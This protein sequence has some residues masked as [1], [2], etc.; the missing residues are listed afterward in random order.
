MQDNVSTDI[1]CIGR[2]SKK[3]SVITDNVDQAWEAF[4][5][6]KNRIE[7]IIP[8]NVDL[9][10]ASHT[11]AFVNIEFR[12]Q[13]TEGEQI[14]HNTQPLLQLTEAGRFHVFKKLRLTDK[15]NMQQL[16]SRGFHI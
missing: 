7:R 13:P 10:R 2:T 15:K 3:Q 5:T 8:E 14:V 16:F 12:L 9:M 1:M 4:G 6:G 11:Q